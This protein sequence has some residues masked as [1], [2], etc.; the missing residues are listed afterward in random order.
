M[1][2]QILPREENQYGRL[3]EVLGAG[4]GYGIGNIA[5][6]P[7][8][9]AEQ[10]KNIESLKGLGFSEQEA[11]AIS[12]QPANV[13]QDIIKNRMATQ[14]QLMTQQ[15]KLNAQNQENALFS[16]LASGDTSSLANILGGLGQQEQIPGKEQMTINP[17]QRLQLGASFLSPQRYSALEKSI[18]GG[19]KLEQQKEEASNRDIKARQAAFAESRKDINQ[20]YKARKKEKHALDEF[21]QLIDRGNLSDSRYVSFLR[22]FNLDIPALLSNDDAVL[23]KLRNEFLPRLK[24]IFGGD[25][26]NQ[27]LEQFM[28]GLPDLIQTDEGKRQLIDIIDLAGEADE[29]YYK[30]MRGIEKKYG[31][32][33]PWDALSQ[34][35]EEAEDRINE[36]GNK[37][38]Q[39]HGF[40]SSD[41]RNQQANAPQNNIEQPQ[42]QQ[43]IPQ[44]NQSQSIPRL[45]QTP[46]G[47]SLANA[48][49]A[50]GRQVVRPTLAAASSVG[51]IPRNIVDLAT[52]V[53]PKIDVAD[54]PEDVRKLLPEDSM[55][56]IEEYQKNPQPLRSLLQSVSEYLPSQEQIKKA[57]GHYLPDSYVNPQNSS[58]E[59]IDD[60]VSDVASLMVGGGAGAAKSLITAGLGNIAKV[61][62]KSLGF[63]KGVQ[64]GS[65]IGVMMLTSLGMGPKLKDAANNLYTEAEALTAG[66]RLPADK[67]IETASNIEKKYLSSGLNTEDKKELANVIG[68][69]K[70]RVPSQNVKDFDLRDVWQIK[71][72]MVEPIDSVTRGSEAQKH[73]FELRSAIDQ[74]LKNSPNKEFSTLLTK[75]DK[76]YEGI[77]NGASANKFIKDSF[78]KHGIAIGAAGA[79]PLFKSL[80]SNP[81]GTIGSI[82]SPWL[83]ANSILMVNN[84][85]KNKEVRNQYVKFIT[86][87]AKNNAP[88]LIKAAKNIEKSAK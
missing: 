32:K 67:I 39:L 40:N 86:A 14:S 78:K 16:A 11:K 37:M 62:P 83:G 66:K 80:I 47:Q 82:A 59:F 31:D 9:R 42:Q 77:K 75:A 61:I 25:V 54:I 41:N 17:D 69:I 81:L 22:K 79:Y 53:I 88:A 73:L 5:R 7:L 64:E 71:K 55:R 76:L 26:S 45:P 43:N 3:A 85:L 8:R 65:K 38:R 60:V 10:E 27:Q 56:Q 30:A 87:A 1:A 70:E 24:S 74:S 51:S 36:L 46:Q 15:H 84:I 28:K 72:D 34:V 20:R 57:F 52:S 21:R 29:V 49:N 19:Q 44:I 13:Q 33:I 58:E 18:R 6:E 23:I 68:Q 4:L 35:N 2:I 50:I 48:S 12:A 63:S